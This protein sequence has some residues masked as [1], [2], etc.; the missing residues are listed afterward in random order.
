MRYATSSTARRREYEA[1]SWWDFLRGRMRA[2]EPAIRDGDA[3]DPRNGVYSERMAHWLREIPQALIA[4]QSA[5]TDARTYGT[6]VDPAAAGRSGRRRDRGLHAERPDLGGLAAPVEALPEAPGRRLLPRQL[7]VAR[8]RQARRAAAGG[9]GTGGRSAAPRAVRSDRPGPSTAGMAG[10]RR[11]P[12]E[13]LAPSTTRD[14]FVL[15]VPIEVAARLARVCTQQQRARRRRERHPRRSGAPRQPGRG[16]GHRRPRRRP[17]RPLHRTPDSR[18]A[19]RCATSPACSTS[20]RAA[21]ASARDTS[22]T[23]TP[24]G[25]CRRSRS[26]P[27]GAI[28]AVRAAR[29]SARSRSTSATGTRL[30][31]S[32]TASV[33]RRS[34]ARRTR[35]HAAPGTSSS[36]AWRKREATARAGAGVLP[37]RP[38]D[39]LRRRSLQQRDALPDQPAEPVEPPARPVRSGAR[40][41]S[42]RTSTIDRLED[43]YDE[44]CAPRGTAPGAPSARGATRT[45]SSIAS[46]TTAGSGGH[47]HGDVHAPH[48]HGG[49]ERVGTPRRQRDPAHR[50]P[51]RRRRTTVGAA[52]LQLGPASTLGDPCAH[53]E[54][55]GAT[56]GPTSSRC[57]GSTRPLVAEGLPHVLDIL[58]VP[59]M[60]ARVP[61][62]VRDDQPARARLDAPA[63]ASP[64]TRSARVCRRW[65]TVSTTFGAQLEE[66][67]RGLYAKLGLGS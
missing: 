13:R 17:A 15:A 37:P 52:A 63:R 47:V 20:S 61:H 12:G 51:T 54:P 28:A 39:R 57:A 41:R 9:R 22:T 36:S 58:R 30:A 1:V 64:A 60:L 45:R 3:T 49:G 44:P 67:L 50:S 19:T 6:I 43:L 5:E 11:S 21:S 26:S 35:S 14:F 66:Q 10:A 46:R 24:S 29:S 55:R 65:P 53:R 48:H 2:S 33:C 38:G 7:T 32:R 42:A 34:A 62:R 59:E 18:R 4:M 56:S 31:I 25:G 27:T 23:P 8:A 16:R 40:G